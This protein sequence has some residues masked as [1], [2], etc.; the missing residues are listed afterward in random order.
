M[1]DRGDLFFSSKTL[2]ESLREQIQDD[3]EVVKDGRDSYVVV[4]KVIQPSNWKLV[5]FAVKVR[6]CR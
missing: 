6:N 1:D 4:S 3:P 5:V 2:S